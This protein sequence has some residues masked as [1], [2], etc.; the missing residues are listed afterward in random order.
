MDGTATVAMPEYACWLSLGGFGSS[1]SADGGV[2]SV[3]ETVWPD[4]DLLAFRLG[5]YRPCRP[6]EVS[7]EG[8]EAEDRKLGKSAWSGGVKGGKLTRLLAPNPAG[9]PYFGAAP[10]L[11]A[12]FSRVAVVERT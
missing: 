11:R 12:T 9:S 3:S 1:V 5:Q 10:K 7:R 4:C 8:N 6:V 2:G